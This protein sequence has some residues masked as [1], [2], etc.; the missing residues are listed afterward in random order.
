MKIVLD[1]NVLLVAISDR[2]K[3]HWLYRSLIDGK[4][5]IFVTN[6]ILN[7]YE[8]KISEHWKPEVAQA[9]IKTLLEL[10]N[11]HLTN[12]YYNL[13]MIYKDPDDNKFVDFACAANCDYLVSN[14]KHFNILK[15]DKFLKIKVL[16][17]EEFKE[18][19]EET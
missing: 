17:L 3:H 4:Y 15:E 8:E 10:P 2:S 9:V 19:F 7:E 14:D 6:E 1:T 11:V 5:E 13:R 16:K 18:I 12:I